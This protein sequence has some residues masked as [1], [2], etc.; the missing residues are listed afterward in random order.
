MPK[1]FSR[2]LPIFPRLSRKEK[3]GVCQLRLQSGNFLVEALVAT[4]VA[5]LIAAALAQMYTQV[6]RAGNM[7][8]GQ[9]YAIAV[10]QECIDQ[11]RVITYANLSS[12]ANMGT[13]YPLVNGRSA[14]INDPIFPHPL[15]KDYDLD[16]SGS[17][18]TTGA[19]PQTSNNNQYV[20]QGS[21]YTFK[22]INPDTG[23]KDDRVKVVLTPAQGVA[24]VQITVEVDY[25]DTS[26]AVKT[27]TTSS[28]IT[29]F[30]IAS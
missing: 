27:F 6:R 3:N 21:S 14:D 24:G 7:S 8:Q 23:Q 1:Q 4:L 22:T 17:T 29:E 30:G 18:T 26:G 12:P 20:I 5:S 2:N 11:A 28:L 10:A 15:M 16:Y 25:L 9:L 13:H 19:N